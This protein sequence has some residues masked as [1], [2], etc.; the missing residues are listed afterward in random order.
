MKENGASQRNSSSN[1]YLFRSGLIG[2]TILMV[3]VIIFDPNRGDP[4]YAASMVLGL[5]GLPVTIAMLLIPF[6]I[7]LRLV[8]QPLSEFLCRKSGPSPANVWIALLAV[9]LPTVLVVP[10]IDGAIWAHSVTEGVA[11][12][13][14][15]LIYA[16][17]NRFA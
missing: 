6:V 10:L 14:S 9:V 3:G 11:L 5:I 15:C 7:L 1:D 8:F 12:G 16:R 4:D 17:R 13:A 2:A